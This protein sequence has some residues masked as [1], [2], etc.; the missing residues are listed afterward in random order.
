[1]AIHVGINPQYGKLSFYDE[2]KKK[3]VDLHINPVL[4]DDVENVVLM[5]DEIKLQING[6]LGCV[7]IFLNKHY[8]NKIR[9]KFIE[10]GYDFEFRNVEIISFETAVYMSAMS[11]TNYKPAN[12]NTIWILLAFSVYVWK[13]ED[14][15]AEFLGKWFAENHSIMKRKPLFI[16]DANVMLYFNENDESYLRK[17]F[18]CLLFSCTFTPNSYSAG[19][20]LKARIAAGD[21]ELF[22]LDT[23]SFLSIQITL[24]I[25][26]NKVTSFGFCQKLPITYAKEITR[27]FYY[28]VLQIT[29]SDGTVSAKLP[30]NHKFNLTFEIDTNEVYWVTFDPKVDEMFIN[31]KSQIL[32][33]KIDTKGCLNFESSYYN[34]PTVPNP[35]N[36]KTAAIGIDLGTSRCCVAVNRKNGINAVPLDSNGERLLP[37]YVAYDEKNVKCGKIVVNRLR[38]HSKSTIFD[39]KRIIGKEFKHIE[40]DSF[41]PF[42]LCQEDNK[43]FIEILGING[44]QKITA[45]EVTSDLLKYIKQKTEE[46]QGVRLSKV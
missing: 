44:R 43:P 28:D 5:F 38:Y 41:W 40:I 18:E 45:E 23:K 37:S 42:D 32:A 1:M 10:S 4:Y 30:D 6:K 17:T 9:K 36:T 8:G 3:T 20:L 7:C 22:H 19:S 31:P 27:K 29:S 26:Y 21:R 24:N 25:G 35:G 11:Q 15:K 12:G 14:Q 39:S 34:I 16:K 2:Y 33:E 13:I 46:F